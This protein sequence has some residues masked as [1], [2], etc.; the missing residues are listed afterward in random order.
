MNVKKLKMMDLFTGLGGFHIAAERNGRIETFMKS[1]I[2]SFN[3]KLIDQKLNLCNAADI[4][5][6]GISEHLHPSNKYCETDE[7]AVE[8]TGL[9]TVTYQDF[10]EGAL[11][12]PDIASGGFP[13]QD[14][15]AANLLNQ[16]GL[17][18]EKSSLVAEQMRL[19]ED[20][21]FPYGVFENAESLNINGLNRILSELNNLGYIVEWETISAVAF[22]YP[23]YRHRVYI[24][25]YLPDT[26]VARNNVRVFDHV[27]QTALYLQEFPFKIAL[28]NE[29]PKWVLDTAV[30][31]DTKSLKLRTK[32]INSLGNAVIPDIPEAIFHTITKCEFDMEQNAPIQPF[33]TKEKAVLKLSDNGWMD[34]SNNTTDRMPTR[35]IMHQGTIYSDGKCELLN[36]PKTRFK[37]LYSTLIR[38]DGNNNFTTTSRLNRPGKLGG[39]VGE[40]MSIGAT[41]GGL[42]PNFCE[43]FMGYPKNHTMLSN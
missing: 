27:R 36:V 35:G 22:N 4:S 10:F 42:H 31:E 11:D 2:D 18:G 26:A 28:L 12:F 9:S 43:T 20:L 38:K 19:L 15:S 21:E 7:V 41:K 8:M 39:L 25:A 14:V 30:L 29:D 34:S 24:A 1:E 33:S 40:I 37:G 3:I 23:H 32:R 16:S 5:N 17:D 6:L 13:C